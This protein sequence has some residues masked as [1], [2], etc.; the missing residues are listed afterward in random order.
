[1]V[2]T[3]V[4]EGLDEGIDLKDGVL[5]Q[6]S[7]VGDRSD[8]HIGLLRLARQATR[9]KP[10][11]LLNV[12]LPYIRPPMLR[13]SRISITAAG[14]RTPVAAAVT[15]APTTTMEEVLSTLITEAEEEDKLRVKQ[16]NEL[17]VTPW[18]V[19]GTSSAG[20]VI[21]AVYSNA[22]PG[23]V[24]S[25]IASRV[26]RNTH[27]GARMYLTPKP[28]PTPL[29]LMRKAA[30]GM[31]QN[32]ENHM[33][34]TEEE[35]RK[36]LYRRQ[37]RDHI[38]FGK[39]IYDLGKIATAGINR[40]LTIT[41]CGQWTHVRVDTK[42]YNAMTA[43]ALVDPNDVWENVISEE[44]FHRLGFDPFFDLDQPAR[45]ELRRF[46]DG[47][48]IP[49]GRKPV[50][51]IMG[52]LQTD[53]FIQVGDHEAR[54][55]CRPM[56]V[57][58][59]PCHLIISEPFLSKNHIHLAHPSF[60]GQGYLAIQGQEIPLIRTIQWK[61][62]PN[63]R[64]EYPLAGLYVKEET[65]IP[66]TTRAI[67]EVT[68][69]SLM[70]GVCDLEEE[71]ALING[72]GDFMR[73]TNLHPW[74][75]ALIRM[76]RQGCSYVGVC[77][78]TD[79]AIVIPKGTRYGTIQL[80]INHA[81]KEKYPKRVHILETIAATDHGPTRTGW[82]I[83][84][85]VKTKQD[86]RATL[87]KWV[88]GSNITHY[89][90]KRLHYIFQ[91][92]Q[93]HNKPKL[94]DLPIT[95]IQM[96]ACSIMAHWDKLGVTRLQLDQVHIYGEEAPMK[97]VQ[98]SDDLYHRA[99]KRLKAQ[100]FIYDNQLWKCGLIAV[101]DRDLGIVK[102]CTDHRQPTV[103]HTVTDIRQHLSGKKRPGIFTDWNEH[104]PEVDY[105]QS[106]AIAVRSRQSCQ[107]LS[108]PWEDEL[109]NLPKEDGAPIQTHTYLR[110]CSLAIEGFPYQI[111]RPFLKGNA[112][113]TP[114]HKEHM[115]ALNQYFVALGKAGLTLLSDAAVLYSDTAVVLEHQVMPI[116][117]LPSPERMRHIRSRILK[118][119]RPN[120]RLILGE[121]AMYQ[122]FMLD[123]DM[124]T[125]P[126]RE[127]I[128][129]PEEDTK[130]LRSLDK[131]PLAITPLMKQAHQQL[132]QALA[133]APVL[134]FPRIGFEQ[135]PFVL[136]IHKRNPWHIQARL[137]QQQNGEDGIIA[138]GNKWLTAQQAIYPQATQEMLFILKFVDLWSGLLRTN[139]FHVYLHPINMKNVVGVEEADETSIKRWTDEIAT[140][141]F[142]ACYAHSP[143]DVWDTHGTRQEAGN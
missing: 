65:V 139:P 118:G 84:V 119:R 117:I 124:I 60:G 50:M 13:T 10:I 110:L 85:I 94:R 58:G 38:N 76:N 72:S 36:Y 39:Y 78:T 8:S 57:D 32:T 88:T 24:T 25:G 135:Q 47:T 109:R 23:A 54:M 48:I 116:G 82:P 86:P 35:R 96:I 59:L 11:T 93:L 42:G 9:S 141:Q 98:V 26:V 87:P 3:E 100:D 41:P 125:V 34:W 103:F 120:I 92:F 142:T 55:R 107:F 43:V 131:I 108:T 115:W 114:E 64:P 19:P 61:E 17:P 104:P 83:N 1:M 79:Q 136:E 52:R 66:A 138:L 15:P 123:F 33:T 21:S 73:N 113:F 14:I 40:L 67:V 121:I 22:E 5:H 143:K 89:R 133:M 80:A 128:A 81:H 132:L 130:S 49:N 74:M 44:L 20:P 37:M 46:K 140:L 134:C 63:I 99:M 97:Y 4:K 27:L 111:V 69:P 106:Q 122:R 101:F 105:T 137:M 62:V 31:G 129:H 7:P 51:Q 127:A 29:A 53:I 95:E 68:A 77:N 30:M 18:T 71:D 28:Y 16:T 102:W 70:I 126:L 91:R 12:A 2:M 6:S 45:Y 56:V 75:N 112:I 90:R